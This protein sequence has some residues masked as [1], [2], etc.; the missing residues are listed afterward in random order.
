MSFGAGSKG[1]C[2]FEV[3]NNGLVRDRARRKRTTTVEFRG[4]LGNLFFEYAAGLTVQQIRG[5][6]LFLQDWRS[7][8]ASEFLA[9][10]DPTGVDGLAQKFRGLRY[11]CPRGPID[12]ILWR[13]ILRFRWMVRRLL[14][15]IGILERFLE[16]QAF[17]S[18]PSEPGMF[19]KRDVILFGFFQHPTWFED[20]LDVVTE[21]IWTGLSSHVE[22]LVDSNA[23]VIS[24]RLSDYVR[25][26]W[27]LLPDYYERAID[28]LGH[29]EGPIWITSDD[30]DAAQ[31]MLEP[32]LRSRNL[33]A[34]PAPDLDLNPAIRDFG[35]LSVARNVIMSNSTFCWWGTVTGQRQGNQ[36]PK[37]IIC[38]TRWIP[39]GSNS[40]VLI[41]ADWIRL[42][43]TF[44]SDLW[45]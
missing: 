40:V 4:R 26:G 13:A 17:A 10:L 14:V 16:S 20:S 42:D 38:P 2:C 27:N 22:H 6:K 24:V 34:S 44:S 39:L 33:V 35:I 18:L 31:A 28:V 36:P 19:E 25:L 15:S 21:K 11:F 45:S 7:P 3:G 8:S 43:A 1:P 41:R 29:I 5:G 32:I 9:Y 30:P 37:T 23:T 12:K